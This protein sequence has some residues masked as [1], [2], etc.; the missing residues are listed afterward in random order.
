[1]KDCWDIKEEC[2]FSDT[3]SSGA[4]CPAYASQTSCWEFDWMSFYHG[5][6]EGSEKDEWKRLM[7]EWCASCEIRETHREVIDSF[8]STLA[9]A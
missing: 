6:P 2:P 8:L 7:L 4:K 3:D 9:R 1:M 5:M